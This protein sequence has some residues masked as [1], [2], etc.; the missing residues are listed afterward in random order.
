[1]KR[2]HAATGRFV[3]NRERAL[4]TAANVQAGAQ[5]GK[6]DKAAEDIHE[7]ITL[8][9]DFLKHSSDRLKSPY[10]IPTDS[11]GAAEDD[12]KARPC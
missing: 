7:T 11:D 4:K 8:E 3:V 2:D 10:S 5:P 6:V 12:G 9:F 1:M